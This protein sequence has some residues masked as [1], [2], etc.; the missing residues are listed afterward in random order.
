MSLKFHPSMTIRIVLPEDAT[1][2]M[3]EKQNLVRHSGE[4]I[5]GHLEIV[6]RGDFSFEILLAF[7]G[8]LDQL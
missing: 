3:S 1:P 5:S 7:E 8:L 2:T 6:T 4:T